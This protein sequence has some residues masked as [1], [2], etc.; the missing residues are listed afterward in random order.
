MVA[1]CRR[2]TKKEKPEEVNSWKVRY[3]V[4]PTVAEMMTI[5]NADPLKDSHKGTKTRSYHQGGY[6]TG[7]VSRVAPHVEEVLMDGMK[8]LSDVQ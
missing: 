4:N 2:Q 6:E 8:H 3:P 1:R 7:R 5:P